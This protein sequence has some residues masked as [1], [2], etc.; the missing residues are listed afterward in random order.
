MRTV[1]RTGTIAIAL[2]IGAPVLAQTAPPPQEQ[3]QGPMDDHDRLPPRLE[4]LGLSPEQKEQIRRILRQDREQTR[5]A[6]ANVL[7]PAQRAQWAAE[8]RDRPHGS[9]PQQGL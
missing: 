2:L 6:I 9:P 8:R 1:L 4:Q 3:A 5:R 7:T